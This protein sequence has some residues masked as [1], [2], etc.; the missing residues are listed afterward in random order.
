DML[1]SPVVLTKPSFGDDVLSATLTTLRLAAVGASTTEA[2][3]RWALALP[4]VPVLRL[5][6]VLAGQCWLA[7][8]GDRAKYHLRAGDCFLIP[9]ARALVLASDLSIKHPTTLERAVRS[10]R[11]GVVR[12]ACNAGASPEVLVAGSAFQLEGHFQA[13]VFGRLPPVIHIPAH[14]ESAAVLRWGIDRLAAEV[15]NA[16]PGRALMLRHLAPLLLVQ[17]FRS[18]LATA[19]DARNWFSA[20]RDPRLARALAAMQTDL[21]HAWSLDKLAKT[22]GLSRAGFALNFKKAIGTTPLEY[23][24]QWR[25][26][27]A[28]ELFVDGDRRIAEVATAVG[29]ESESAF[30]AAFTRV[31]G[32]RP[33]HYRS[34]IAA[35]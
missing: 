24:T 16:Q 6:V 31:V 7:V 14:A 22:A 15:S 5:H 23:L 13:I 25:V 4:S 29:Y 12:I 34:R 32:E 3:G 19:G 17:T 8:D 18:Y 33:G 30:S 27:V 21:A 11:D 2:S 26:Q 28:R 20:L 1:H 35:S 9:H 10:T